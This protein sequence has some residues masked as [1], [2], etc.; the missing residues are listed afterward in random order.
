MSSED[1]A[2]GA[3]RPDDVAL[4][5]REPGLV[6]RIP[7][8]ALGTF[9]TPVERHELDTA[10]GVRSILV[11]RDDRCADG[12]AGNKVRKLEFV[13][14]DARAAGAGRL[15]TVGATGSHHAFATAFHGRRVG[16]PVSLVLFPQSPTPHVRDMLL[17]DQAAGADLRWVARMEGV[18][19]ALWRTRVKHRR[20]R[21][22]VVP[23]GGSSAVGTLGYVSAAL[24]L[25]EQVAS[26]EAPLPTRIHV[27]AGTLGTVAG[28]AIGLAWSGLDVPVIA[29]RI[30]ARVVTN[31]RVL[32]RLVRATL[33]QLSSLGVAVPD[34]E[35]VLRLVE[36]RHDQLGAG[37]GQP[38]EAASLAQRTFA[39][40]GLRLDT[41]Y[42]AKAAASLLADDEGGEP[43]FWHTLSAIEPRE[44]ADTVTAA[45]LP[46]RFAAYC[47][48]MNE[49][50]NDTER[51]RTR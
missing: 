15:I 38:T 29:T 45:D 51:Q 42:T 21:P 41:T 39:E 30:T 49:P 17:L 50:P 6:G 16:L 32:A 19:W 2:H 9:P 24:E 18:P 25:A 12:Y 31:E 47:A 44:L 8:V 7:R 34:A 22:Y 48:S 26:G 13:L 33:L 27:A 40:A 23:P 37:Y 14:A 11:K 36:L 43:L 35:A 28:I 5:R 46:P 20:E 3:S 10:R 1:V 4:F